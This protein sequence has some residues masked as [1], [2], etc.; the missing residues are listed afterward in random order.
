MPSNRVLDKEALLL[1]ESTKG[2][3][4]ARERDEWIMRQLSSVV[5]PMKDNFFVVSFKKT[6]NKG[7]QSKKRPRLMEAPPVQEDVG[8]EEEGIHKLATSVFGS[9]LSLLDLQQH[10]NLQFDQLR[11][12]QHSTRIMMLYLSKSME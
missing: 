7:E 12:I 10:Y 8:E 4:T 5:K 2:L 3:T 1:R 9:R 6:K 11:R